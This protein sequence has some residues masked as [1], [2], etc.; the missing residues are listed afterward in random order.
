MSEMYHTY[1]YI[2]FMLKNLHI[3]TIISYIADIIAVDYLL[4]TK[5]NI[6]TPTSRL[7][8]WGEMHVRL[9]RIPGY[10][11]GT[12]ITCFHFLAEHLSHRN[13]RQ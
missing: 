10:L 6:V 9:C 2:F 1:M 5:L 13:G 3:E 8:Q 7:L 12:V 4:S 11:T